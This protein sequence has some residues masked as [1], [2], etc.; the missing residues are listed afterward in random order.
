[1]RAF[2]ICLLTLAIQ[3][4]TPPQFE[5]IQREQLALGG[6]FVNAW[7]DADGDGDPDLFVGFNGTPNRLYRNDAGVLTDIAAEA[8]VADAR[9]TRAAAWGDHDAD[10][11]PDLLVGFAPGSGSV[12]R[13]YRNDSARSGSAAAPLRFTD[14]TVASGLVIPTGAVR[15]PAWIDVDADGDLDLFV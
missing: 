9:G 7:A 14:I 3:T 8:G 10:G 12:L 5:P 1:M 4:S 11:D 2:G 6:S 13:L 15:Q